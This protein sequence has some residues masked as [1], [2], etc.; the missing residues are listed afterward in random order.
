MAN[1]LVH[2][3]ASKLPLVPQTKEISPGRMMR[4]LLRWDP[5]EEMVPVYP[6][7]FVTFAPAFEVKETRDAFLFRADIPGMK[8]KD[9]E[10]NLIGNRLS[11]AGERTEEDVQQGETYYSRE[12]SYGRFYR[13]FTLPEGI[14]TDHVHATL[15]AGVL[16][17]A[18][19]KLP[20]VQAKRIAVKAAKD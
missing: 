19:S 16:T 18:I 9:I 11:I 12:R 4:E 6:T 13:S 20:E 2:R 17:V 15:E 14:D 7:E 1:L 8:E 3:N 5:F 10:V